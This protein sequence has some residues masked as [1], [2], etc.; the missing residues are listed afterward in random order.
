MPINQKDVELLIRARNLSSQP[1]KEVTDSVNSVTKALDEQIKAAER[2]DISASELNETLKKLKNS[3]DAL[4]KQSALIDRMRTLA[5]QL[6]TAE[7]NAEEAR[8]AVENFSAGSSKAAERVS[9]LTAKLGEAQEKA[10]ATAA[11]LADF[12]AKTSDS[13]LTAKQQRD[14]ERLTAARDRAATAA[15]TALTK[16]RAAEKKAADEAAKEQAAVEKAYQRAQE[17]RDRAAT[18]AG[19]QAER[20]GG[21]GISATP[22]GLDAASASIY[23][24]VAQTSAAIKQIEDAQAN[25][26][27]VRRKNAEAAQAAAAA[28]REYEEAMARSRAAAERQAA[29]DRAFAEQREA[30]LRRMREAE[31]ALLFDELDARDRAKAARDKELADEKAFYAQ[32][33][34]NM[35]KFKE[36]MYAQMFDEIEAREKAN[37]AT[38]DAIKQ[39]NALRDAQMREAEAEEQNAKATR[40]NTDAK[41]KNNESREKSRNSLNLFNN[42]SRESLSLYQRIRGQILAV[43]AAYIGLQGAID[44]A[45]G[46][47]GALVDKQA[48]EN[49]LAIVVG[50]DP[51]KIGDEY[52]Y[53][54]D[55]AVRLGMGV[56]EMADS[57]SNFA[58]AA[59]NGNLN[60]EQ[61]RYAFER[62]TEAMRVNHASS[63]AVNGAFTQL[64]QMLSKN[65]IQMDDLRQA[66]SWIPGL[67]AMMA[68]GLAN[69]GFSGFNELSGTLEK[70]KEA[71]PEKR[72]AILFKAMKEGGVDAKLAIMALAE[73]LERTYKDRLPD[74]LKSLQAE[75]GR[76]NTAFF[77]FKLAIADAGFADAATNLF[78]RLTEALKGEQ[79]AVFAKNISEAFSKVADAI[80]WLVDHFDDLLTALKLIAEFKMLQWSLSFAT[81]IKGITEAVIEFLAKSVAFNSSLKSMRLSMGEAEVGAGLLNKSLLVIRSTLMLLGA[82]ITGWEIGTWLREKFDTVRLAGIA[83][84]SGLMDMWTNIKYGVKIGVDAFVLEIQMGLDR[85]QTMVEKAAIA[86][87]KANPVISSQSVDR[88]QEQANA[89]QAERAASIQNRAKSILDAKAARDKEIADRHDV[90]QQEWEYEAAGG[91]KAAAARAAAQKAADEASRPNSTESPGPFGKTGLGLEEKDKT[92][93]QRASMEEAL[94]NQ[95]RSIDAKI[96]RQQ[97]ESLDARLKAVDDTYQRI[98]D[99]LDQFQKLGGKSIKVTDENGDDRVLTIEQYKEQLRQQTELLKKQEEEKFNKE[100]VK[101]L[102]EDLNKLVADRKDQLGA[103][104]DDLKSG[105]I[106]TTEAFRRTSAVFDEMNPKIDAAANKAKNFAMAAQGKG[107]TSAE[108]GAL[109]S[110]VDRTLDMSTE[111]RKQSLAILGDSESRINDLIKQRKDIIQ[112]NNALVELGLMTQREA[113]EQLEKQNNAVA[114]KIRKQ[115]DQMLEVLK[116]MRDEGKITAEDFDLWAAKIGLAKAQAVQLSEAMTWAKNFVE[117][118]GV[119]GAQTFFQSLAQGVAGVATGMKSWADAWRDLRNAM[120]QYFADLLMQLGLEIIKRQILNAIQSSSSSGSSNGAGGGGGWLGAIV[121]VIGSYFGGGS[122]GSF[123]GGGVVG[124]GNTASRPVSAGW[125]A[126]APRYHNGGLPGLAPDEEAAILK[127]GEEVLTKDDPRNVLNSAARSGGAPAAAMK[128]QDIKIVNAIDSHSVLEQALST[129]DGARLI[130]NTLRANRTQLK[131]L[132]NN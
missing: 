17:A 118:S 31:Y 39:A 93:A 99:K 10:R 117:E 30:N 18:N 74:A 59:K 4:V 15:E 47:L 107:V 61:T 38:I 82:F 91:D 66:S 98:Y 9:V 33:D 97:K 53:V 37:R 32:R 21:V 120:L 48:A 57:Y 1:L 86:I 55:Q 131:V 3:E 52:A 34:A 84:T 45:T 96:E 103:I 41:N 67:E 42:D 89:N 119:K 78:K 44:L 16:L 11:A 29:E 111:E 14:L 54:H 46:A 114:P 106:D 56:K 26:A 24:G 40:D 112:A 43:A 130:L 20:L 83:L 101:S 65:K 127:H 22:E 62:I 121:N 35:R 6:A 94:A 126:D 71:E 76:L 108:A 72:V 87:A 113:Q 88:M 122:G 73:E 7:R 124:S 5:E 64:E 19:R 69:Q 116:K 23:G 60:L 115:A 80:I 13:E 92:A 85:L 50:N 129:P 12:Q 25:L 100:K 109:G 132:L 102:E 8:L 27:A 81:G 128:P 79:G 70:M 36:A 104:A 2:G 125:F 95:L 63:D 77:D 123:H 75:Q 58:I 105:A 110:K 49:R 51:K 68:R 28:E 90:F